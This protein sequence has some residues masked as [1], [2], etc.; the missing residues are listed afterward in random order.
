MTSTAEDLFRKLGERY[1]AKGKPVTTHAVLMAL[2]F[3][4][5][6]GGWKMLKQANLLEVEPPQEEDEGDAGIF[7]PSLARALTSA[8]MLAQGSPL[9]EPSTFSAASCVKG[10]A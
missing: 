6:S 4:E 5:S 8:A 1:V 9:G 3:K 10:M 2:R 7:S